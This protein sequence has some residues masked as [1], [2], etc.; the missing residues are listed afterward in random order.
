MNII[1]IIHLLIF[2]YLSVG[3][4]IISEKY[5]PVYLLTIIYIIIDWNDKDGLCWITKLNNMIKYKSFNPIIQEENE[6]N[7][8]KTQLEKIGVYMEA[9]KITFI[10]YIL[11]IVS[12]LVAYSRLIKKYNIKVFP[13]KITQNIVYFFILSWILVTYL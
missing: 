7:F 4:Y 11:F 9:K 6:N 1:E 13:N 8:I 10:L 3:G 2:F 12:W 5:I